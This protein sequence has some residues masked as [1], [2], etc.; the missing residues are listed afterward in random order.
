[1]SVGKQSQTLPTVKFITSLSEGT[2]R[3]RSF[4]TASVA[5]L[6][7]QAA[8]GTVT[9]GG[10]SGRAGKHFDPRSLA[11][12]ESGIS[13]GSKPRLVVGSPYLFDKLLGI[14]AGPFGCNV[15]WVMKYVI[16]DSLQAPSVWGH[17]GVTQP[18]N[19]NGP[20]LIAPG[21]LH[22]SPHTPAVKVWK[23]GDFQMTS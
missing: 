7:L 21:S 9:V 11:H 16:C 8:E 12:A 1:M 14:F 13:E 22:L 2:A 15:H 17:R 20:L 5:G 18:L 23:A 19:L 4:S 6:A 10:S 3:L